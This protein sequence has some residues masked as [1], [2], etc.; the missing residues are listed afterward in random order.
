M[1]LAG[2]RSNRGDT[3]QRSVAIHFIVEMLL[4]DEIEGVQVDSVAIP[5]NDE[6]IFGDDIVIFKADGKKCYIQAKVNQTLHHLWSIT[7]SVLKK[8]LLAAREQ[9]LSDT[10]G[11]FHFY[12]RT[13][14]GDFQRFIEEVKLYSDYPAFIRVSAKKHQV[15]LA[16][17][18]TLWEIEED[19][20]LSLSQ[21]IFI[22][23]HN[24]VEQ[25]D[26]YCLSLL[27]AHFSQPETTFELLWS[28]IDKQH[29]KLGVPQYIIDRAAVFD[30]LEK[31]GIHHTLSFDEQGLVEKFRIFSQ[32]G[33]QWVRSIGGNVL[34]R[35][36]LS[37]LKQAVSF[38][39]S[40]VLLEDIAGGGKTCILLDLVDY[41]DTQEG[42]ATLFIKGDLFSSISSLADLVDYGLPSDL[43]SQCAKLADHRQLVVVIDSLDVLAV[44]RSHQALQCLIG[45][46][47]L[48]KVIPNI[49]V[50][51]A[52]RSFDAK[53]DP[54]LRE[55]EWSEKIMVDPL[56]YSEEIAPF[57]EKWGVDSN[58]ISGELQKLL[59]I[60]QN[61][62][63]FYTLVQKGLNVAGI[64]GH[65]L[66]D[67]YIREVIEK[68]SA[69]GNNVVIALQNLA[70][71]LLKKRSYVFHK[72]RLTI[73]GTKIQR[74]LSHQIFTEV[75]AF[76]LMFSHQT[77]TDALRIRLAQQNGIVLVDFVNS[78]PQFPFI[79]PAIRAFIQALRIGQPDLFVKQFL[80]LLRHPKVAVHIK[81][82]AVETFS[83]MSPVEKDIII[84]RHLSSHSSTLFIRFLGS[85]Q[86]V[87][88]FQLL[89]K[90][91]LPN[92]N[93][94]SNKDILGRFL[95]YS[96]KFKHD[97][98]KKLV[99]EWGQAL[100]EEWLPVHSLVWSIPSDLCD[101][102]R[103]DL[104]GIESLLRRLLEL[105]KGERDSVGK[106]I[107]R[108]VESTGSADEL[109]WQFITQD[110][111]PINEI[112]YG[113]EIKLHCQSH[114]LLSKDY[115]E[116]RLKASDKLFGLA[117]EYLAQFGKK[118]EENERWWPMLL[119]ETSW[120]RRH[121]KHNI[122][123]YDSIHAFLNAIESAMKE[124]ASNNDPCWQQNE[125]QIRH[126]GEYGIRYLLCEAY[127][128]NIEENIA[129]IEALLMD[130]ELLRY[131]QLEYEIGVLVSEAY[132]F[133]SFDVQDK[134]QL[135]VMELYDDLDEEHE[136]VDRKKFEYLNWVP[137]PYRLKELGVFFAKCEKEL[138][139]IRP[140]PYIF[141][142]GGW[143][144]SPVSADKMIKLEVN[145]LV[146]LLKHYNDYHQWD[147]RNV[148]ILIGGRESIESSLSSAT[149][150]VPKQFIPLI[151]L[152][153]QGGLTDKYIFSIVDGVST[154]LSARFG[155]CQHQGWHE[156][157]PLPDGIALALELL[158]LAELYYELDEREYSTVRAIQACC[159][160]LSDKL[161]LDRICLQ[162][163]RLSKSDNPSIEQDDDASS[164]VGSGI[165]STRG[166]AAE[167]VVMLCI[168]LLEEERE[169][170][171]EL[172]HLLEV[173]ASDQSM[174]VRATFLRRFPYLLSKQTKMGWHLI[175]LLMQ[176]A[177]P[178]LLKHFEQ[179]L[180]YQYYEHF[181]LVSPVLEILLQTND[182]KTARAWGRVAALSYLSGH[183]DKTEFFHKIE[184]SLSKGSYTGASQVFIQNVISAKS[185]SIC[186]DGLT[187]L[188][189][190]GAPDA[191][192]SKF[193]HSL[194][195]QGRVKYIPGSLIILAIE[196]TPL[197]KFREIDGLFIWM[198][199]V[200]LTNAEDVLT[201]MERL[202]ERL[203]SI[204]EVL[205]F[206]RPEHL[207]TT[208]KLLLQE[209]DMND[210]ENFINRVLA[211]QDW[212][213]D[214]NVDGLEDLLEGV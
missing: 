110:V 178:R 57:I 189:K 126:S 172:K 6:L 147:N 134:F 29:S 166:I 19:L 8:E 63:L 142:S 128:Y 198:E 192:Y 121:S 24:S 193:V 90:E 213:L 101:L 181:E 16:Q 87:D 159:Y 37:Q 27:C 43:V 151:P 73:S 106:A 194:E 124:R 25:W 136:W 174:V 209:A 138:G 91:W 191:V 210:D 40:S 93:I 116:Q 155:N 21:Q 122:S 15:V 104:A 65:D 118:K 177:K 81:R 148:E 154:H 184:T 33:R 214:N 127:R 137:A 152:I 195:E 88:W 55:M 140:E 114:E 105:S 1:S 164:L 133:L 205:N 96:A 206:Y 113:R 61:L 144:G 22:G 175:G 146:R 120:E 50:I 100:D 211:V 180:Y 36:I 107:C 102:G 157:N 153:K 60:P 204:T 49:C 41:L 48:L 3:Y 42:I 112:K 39:V 56:S 129:G 76:Q 212:F 130:R 202:I 7:D 84:L 131:S 30:M 111:A 68:D 64:E 94:E 169:I 86:S 18:A 161:S 123:P 187:C 28:Y 5:G 79:R 196:N 52:S 103:W 75:D 66:Y 109:L 190:L 143:V 199:N 99:S 38:K 132:P 201:L 82:L 182:D 125:P 167:C 69:L 185:R 165:N 2:I 78:Q 135:S 32:Q 67:S 117:I 31:H 170:T 141:S 53:Y 83:E 26:T 77:L 158:S 183:M 11:E 46:I 54:L 188:M 44:G 97:F 23:S 200:V 176:D 150:L 92:I 108:F 168:K 207:V 186:I 10:S 160:V 179:S 71:D 14:F 45:L 89:H 197:T 145:S 70:T 98:P 34:P 149:S 95:Y 208:L 173:F 72:S 62:R 20:A 171:N 162:L 35:A 47:A 74:L 203:S 163:L 51:A 17:L 119:N 4:G 115:L 9:L 80:G 12:S 13:P 139:D 156:V 59:V 58:S 85:A